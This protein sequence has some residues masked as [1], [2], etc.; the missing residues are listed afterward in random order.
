MFIN[1]LKLGSSLKTS[2][3]LVGNKHFILYTMCQNILSPLLLNHVPHKTSHQEV[4]CSR[5]A[6]DV[7]EMYKKR[8]ARAE[9]LFALKINCFSFFDVLV[10][11]V[12][13]RELHVPP[14]L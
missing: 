4:S 9:L 6:V 8:N 11:V 10:V 2:P 12:A 7:E 1:F 13:L 3:R 14:N 5:R